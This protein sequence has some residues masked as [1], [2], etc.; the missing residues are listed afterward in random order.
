MK[1]Q[2][3]F[4][5]KKKKIHADRKYKSKKVYEVEYRRVINNGTPSEWKSYYGGKY[6]TKKQRD[7]AVDGMN[8]AWNNFG[9]AYNYRYEYRA[10]PEE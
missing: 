4:P 8:K 1:P 10:K 7:Q 9:R 5:E 2:Q 6:R 3:P